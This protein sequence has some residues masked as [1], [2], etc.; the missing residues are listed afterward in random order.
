[1]VGK[2]GRNRSIVG[3]GAG[4]GLLGKALSSRRS[5]RTVAGLELGE[6]GSVI[7]HI[8]HHSHVGV[9]LRGGANHGR[10]ADID[11]FHRIVIAAG[12][13]DRRL[14]R[15]EIDHEKIDG[16]DAVCGKCGLVLRVVAHCEQAAMHSRVQG[17]HPSVHHLGKTG[18]LG[19]LR[20]R[21]PASVS[22]RWVPPVETRATPRSDSARAKS[23]R[24]VLS[25][26]ER[27]ARATR[28]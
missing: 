18:D 5:E 28:A 22:A 10:T 23:T 6:D 25:E 3:G 26:T 7:S 17:L 12:F 15:V 11:V 4:K 27:S 8:H 14:E 2:P 21:K 20:D 24:P 13:R 19:H 9:V 16:A 1:M